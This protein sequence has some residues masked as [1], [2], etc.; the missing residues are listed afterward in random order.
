MDQ[1]R[2]SKAD[3]TTIIFVTVFMVLSVTYCM[4][5]T[6]KTNEDKYSKQLLLDD[7]I[8]E[9]TEGVKL[10]LGDVQKDAANPLFR[11]DKPWEPRFDNLYANVCYD[12]ESQLYRCWYSPF[13]IDP[14]VSETPRSDWDKAKYS[15]HDREMGVCYAVSH[16]GLVWEKPSLGVV[17]FNGSKENNLVVRG[18][19]GAGV[20]RDDAERDAQKR[21]KMIFKDRVMS[22]AFSPDGIHWSEAKACDEMEAR[23]DTHNNAFWCTALGN[24]VGI[25]RL[26]D[27]KDKKRLVGRTESSDFLNWTKAVEVLRALSEETDRQTYAMPVFEYANVYLGLLMLID[28]KTDTVDCELAWSPDTVSWRRVCPGDSLIPRGPKGSYDWG[29]V[30]GAAY[31]VFEAD[32]I[33]LYYGGSNGK[34]TSWRDGFFCLAHLR[35]DGF[36]GYATVSDSKEGSILTKLFDYQGKPIAISADAKGGKVQVEILNESG[37]VIAVSRQPIAENVTDAVVEWKDATTLSGLSRQ[38]I[39][40]RFLL[41]SACLYSFSFIGGA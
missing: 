33:R 36:A 6:M 35:P 27:P 30:Y 22:V 4:A 31:P 23:G 26:W 12:A 40:L 19:H 11:E 32:E 38:K 21:Y 13:I 2:F 8:I 41:R 16:D 37:D 15:P 29:C 18:P 5:Q 1:N 7:R 10:V 9:K 24:Y 14:A 28:K 20:F 39:R 25:T 17:E 34:H 3:F